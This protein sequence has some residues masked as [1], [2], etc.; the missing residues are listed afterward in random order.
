MSFRERVNGLSCH[1]IYCYYDWLAAALALMCYS[2]AWNAVRVTSLKPSLKSPLR[3]K[4]KYSEVL[5]HNKRPIIKPHCRVLSSLIQ[6][7]MFLDLIVVNRVWYIIFCWEVDGW[8]API[9]IISHITVIL[10][11]V[12]PWPLSRPL[13]HLKFYL[14]HLPSSLPVTKQWKNALSSHGKL[15]QLDDPIVTS[16]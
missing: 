3:S 14:Y 9:I 13:Y 2:I 4:H 8:L 16:E 7:Q 15:S 10:T 1:M 5:N 12:P 6:L 11:V